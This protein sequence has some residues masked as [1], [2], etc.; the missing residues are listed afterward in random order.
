M[1]IAQLTTS[2]TLSLN[3]FTYHELFHS[4]GLQRLDEI[5]LKT[6]KE[7]DG[8]L[9]DWL[10]AYRHGKHTTNLIETSDL[11]IGCAKILESFLAELFGI[12]EAVAISQAK[13]ISNN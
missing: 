7:S 8:A 10:L 6:L 9:H 3:G 4:S 5:F 11:L 12:E 13:T 2:K 1:T